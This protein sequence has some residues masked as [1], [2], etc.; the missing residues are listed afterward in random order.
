MSE[1]PVIRV[2]VIDDHEMILQSIVRLLRDDPQIVVVGAALTAT[3]GIELTQRERPDVV[4]IDYTL[5]DMDA[6]DA[7]K[8]LR[9]VYPEVKIITFSGSERP[10]ALYA[11]IRAGSSG[12]VRKTR[13]IQELRDAVLNVAAGRPVGNEEM[14][15]LPPLDQLVLHYQPIVVLADGRI[16]GFEA[17]VSWQHPQR[18]LLYPV[19]FL[20]LAQETGFIVE[21]DEWVWEQAAHQ[22]RDWQQR[23][24]SI[25]RIFVRVN[26]SV[27]DLSDPDLFESLSVIIKRSNIDPTDL[28]IEVTES[29]LLDDTEQTMEFLDQ[30]DDLGLGLALDDFGTAFSSL[31]YVRRFPFDHLKLDISF[32]SELPRSIRTMLLVEEICH[33]ATSMKMKSI[34]EG[35]ERQEQADAL[36]NVGCEY[37]QGYL[38][39]RPL[40]VEDCEA[41]LAA[42]RGPP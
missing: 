4:I 19:A 41:L 20:P 33:L 11:S 32:T 29:V 14:E 8:I 6:P 25:P 7:I 12:W 26:M 18:G 9:G 31:S 22:L 37:G 10:G 35:I 28:I 36:R 5:P 30:L 38:F 16:V 27:N 34:A 21:I 13:A 17:L 2:V 24:T 42:G 15:S 23:F 3:Q 1:E 40:S 39:S